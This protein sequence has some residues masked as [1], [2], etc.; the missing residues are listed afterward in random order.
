MPNR[1]GTYKVNVEFYFDA[2]HKWNRVGFP[3]ILSS[4]VSIRLIERLCES[5][6]KAVQPLD[7]FH[8]KH[9]KIKQ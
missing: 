3:H 2:T 9:F 5:I 6:F 8:F 7:T 1:N 4:T